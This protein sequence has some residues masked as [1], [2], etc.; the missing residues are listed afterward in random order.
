MA[1]IPTEYRPEV[2]AFADRVTLDTGAGSAIGRARSCARPPRFEP[3]GSSLDSRN[4]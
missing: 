2:D 4:H 3:I 1:Q